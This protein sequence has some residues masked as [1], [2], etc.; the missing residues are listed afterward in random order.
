MVEY[1]GKEEKYKEEGLN[2]KYLWEVTI[3]YHSDHRKHRF[4]LAEE[5]KKQCKIIFINRKLAIKLIMDCRTTLARKF[6]TRLGLKQFNIILT[7][8]QSVL[9]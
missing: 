2:H 9:T 6:K 3:K 4:E 1:Y 7:K 5:P 8:E